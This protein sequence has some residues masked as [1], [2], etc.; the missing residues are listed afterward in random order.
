MAK[1]IA[2]TILAQLGG[3]RFVIMTGAKNFVSGDNSLRFKLD[4]GATGGANL[5]TVRL[6][7]ND[8]YTVEI[9]KYRS[10]TVT[11]LASRSD[12]YAGSLRSVFTDMTGFS[13]GL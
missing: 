1:Q 2:Q 3:K 12:V 9:A 8:T 11:K 4:R 6:D 7:A 13:T 10:L 5:C